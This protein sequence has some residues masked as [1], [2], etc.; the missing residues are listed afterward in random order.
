MYTLGIFAEHFISGAFKLHPGVRHTASAVSFVVGIEYFLVNTL[1]R[2]TKEEVFVGR[3]REIYYYDELAAV[4][5]DSAIGYD[6]VL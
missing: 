1:L 6:A 5:S 2:N 3:W 4:R